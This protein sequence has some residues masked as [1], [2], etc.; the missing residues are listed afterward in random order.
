MSDWETELKCPICNQL[1]GNDRHCEHLIAEGFDL[2]YSWEDN[3]F[4]TITD[5]IN[6]LIS[7]FDKKYGIEDSYKLLEN[8]FPLGFFDSILNWSNINEFISQHKL[9]QKKTFIN[10]DS[11]VS[12]CSD[13]FPYC[14]SPPQTL[15]SI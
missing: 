15:H 8:A 12:G 2:E 13:A 1:F 5:K 11:R 7:V 10:E 3:R 14:L 4:Q 9:V 6:D